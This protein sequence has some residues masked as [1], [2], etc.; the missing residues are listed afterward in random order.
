MLCTLGGSQKLLPQLALSVSRMHVHQTGLQAFTSVAVEPF[1][2]RHICCFPHFFC[3]LDYREIG[4]LGQGNFSKVL[5]ARHRLNGNEYA[6]KRS[7]RELSPEDP[8]FAQFLQVCRM[9]YQCKGNAGMSHQSEISDCRILTMWKL[10]QAI[11][12][13]SL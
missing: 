6:I 13:F 1:L 3:R 2:S 7:L 9:H 5:R 4:Q 10:R 8:A 11:Q 12:I